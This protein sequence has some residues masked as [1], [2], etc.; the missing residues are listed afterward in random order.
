LRLTPTKG[1]PILVARERSGEVSLVLSDLHFGIIE[2]LRLRRPFPEEEAMETF[3]LIA[4]VGRTVGAHRVV[5]LGD[6]KHGIYEPT[7]YERK[8]LRVLTESLVQEYEVWIMKGNHDYGIEECID[9]GV[10]I[11][12]K[13]GLELDHTVF[14]HGHSLPRMAHDMSSYDAVVSGHVHP[15]WLIGGE[16][17]PVWMVLKD[18]KNNKPRKVVLLP[19]FSRYASRVGYRP[20]PPMVIAPFLKRL[21]LPNFKYEVR[22]LGL[23]K[24]SEGAGSNIMEAPGK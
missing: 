22:D 21:N 24:M 2:R 12:G 16:W 5:M 8:S 19:H 13:G 17:E 6:L 7:V 15:Q 23:R 10:M 4:G 11:I 9:P 18:S 20:G 14:L 1:A 3:R